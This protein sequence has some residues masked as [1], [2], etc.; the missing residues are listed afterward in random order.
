MTSP[1]IYILLFSI[2]IGVALFIFICDFFYNKGVGETE[3]RWKDAVDKKD[4]ADRSD[5]WKRKS[6]EIRVKNDTA[7][8]LGRISMAVEK[9]APWI[10]DEKLTPKQ[11]DVIGLIVEQKIQHR[12]TLYADISSLWKTQSERDRIKEIILKRI[13]TW[14]RTK[15][16]AFMSSHRNIEVG[17]IDQ[18][19]ELNKILGEI[20]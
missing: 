1:E 4:A 8:Q 16:F 14:N 19:S 3:Q 20:G 11:K 2:I 12:K 5:Y 17:C 7:V 9:W 15:D 10:M 6:D 18:I 13:A